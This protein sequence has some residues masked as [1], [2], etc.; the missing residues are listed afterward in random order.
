MPSFLLRGTTAV[1]RLESQGPITLLHLLHNGS[2]KRAFTNYTAHSCIHADQA[3]HRRRRRRCAAARPP[4]PC[5]ASTTSASRLAAAGG[6]AARARRCRRVRACARH[7]SSARRR[8]CCCMCP[9]ACRHCR[10]RR[11]SRPL[12][13]GQGRAGRQVASRGL[14]MA[15]WLVNGHD[16]RA[17][18]HSCAVQ[19]F[20]PLPTRL[21]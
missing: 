9:A 15:Q 3:M 11:A 7:H 2:R 10:S 13:E 16:Q 5:S 6:A 12:Q 21:A 1:A 4:A 18:G 8:R 20:H 17:A 19:L 14:R